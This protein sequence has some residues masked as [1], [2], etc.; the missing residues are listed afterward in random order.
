MADDTFSLFSRLPTELREEIWRCCLPHRVSEMDYPADFI[1][2]GSFDDDD[3]VPCSLQSTSN[4][5][6]R[7][8][9][10]TR[11][12]HLAY[13]IEGNPV[14]SLVRESKR[15]NGSASIML[16]YISDGFRRYSKQRD[17]AVFKLLPKWLVVTRVIVIHL[18][19]AQAAKTGLFG[20][21]GD[22]PV[23]VVDAY[24]PLASQLYE[25]AETCERGA[26]ALTAAQNFARMSADDMNAMVK[27]QA[28][29]VFQEYDLLKRM[30]PAIMFRLCT[31]MCNHSNTPEEEPKVW[32]GE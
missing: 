15:L 28:F 20:L 7:P 19:S 6:G 5:N 31:Q 29:E 10:L 22:A 24:S 30:R 1:V 2:Y 25:L 27:R 8:P 16:H 18:D 17:L 21:L 12:C 13:S 14:E 9:L 26:Y 3:K 23:Q 4:N 11:V 32:T